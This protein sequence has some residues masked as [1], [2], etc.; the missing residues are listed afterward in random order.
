MQDADFDRTG[1]GGV[2]FR[3]RKL[4]CEGQR[5]RHGAELQQTASFHFLG[6][7]CRFG[8]FEQIARFVL[9][10][11][12]QL[13]WNALAVRVSSWFCF[14]L[15]S[16]RGGVLVHRRACVHRCGAKVPSWNPDL[17]LVY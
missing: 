2:G 13:G 3:D 10:G 14:F 11:I 9:Q 16:L 4:A 8:L 17:V 5:A 15:Y 1:V 6:S 7:P 12:C